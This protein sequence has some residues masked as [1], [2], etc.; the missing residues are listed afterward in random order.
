MFFIRGDA[1][2]KR[3]YLYNKVSATHF[4]TVSLVTVFSMVHLKNAYKTYNL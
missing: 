2:L 1:Y 3:Q 4:L